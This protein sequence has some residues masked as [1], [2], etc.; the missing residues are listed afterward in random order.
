M[1]MLMTVIMISGVELYFVENASDLLVKVSPSI[2]TQQVAVCYSF[3][4]V[5]WDTVVATWDQNKYTAVI[6]SPDSLKVI[7]MY[8]LY[9]GAAI[10][11]NNGELYLYEVSTSPRFLYRISLENLGTMLAQVKKKV[12]SK[13]HVDEAML[14]LEYVGSILG[15]VP[16]IPGSAQEFQKNALQSELNTIYQLLAP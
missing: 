12:L 15:A 4:S 13:T 16:Y 14:V 6:H 5:A 1:N 9:D 8:C 7:G 11:D 2:E 10:D 3:H